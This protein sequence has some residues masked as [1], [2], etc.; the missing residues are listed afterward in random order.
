VSTWSEFRPV[1][2]DTGVLIALEGADRRLGVLLARARELKQP[3]LIPAGVLAQ[4]WRDGARQAR[5]ARLIRTSHVRVVDLTAVQARAAGELCGRRG[6]S[7][8]IDASVVILARSVRAFVATSDPHDLR[9][10]DPEL[11]LARV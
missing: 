2:F 7:D 4:A 6:T 10:L 5:L 1:V 3:I 9:H 8:V 11:T